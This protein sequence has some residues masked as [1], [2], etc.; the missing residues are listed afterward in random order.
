MAV[1]SPVKVP[2]LDYEKEMKRWNHV[3][4]ILSEGDP[5][6][7]HSP[8]Q[9]VWRKN[10]TTLWHYAA[11]EKKY[12]TPLFFVYSL[13]NKPYI[14]DIS[15]D[16]SVIKGLTKRGYDVY[17][18]DWG[19]PGPE[20]ADISFDTYILDY[21]E[22]GV[23]RAL[24]HSGAE[25]ISVVGYCLGGT[26]ASIFASITDLPIKNLVVA[27]VPID[28]SV[29][30][31]PD[32][33]LEGL[34]K[35]ELSVDRFVDVYGT[36][37][38]EW[39]NVMFRSL[40]PVN[41]SPYVG[42]LTRAHDSRYVDKWRRMDK[43]LNDVTPFAGAAFKQMFGDLMKDNKLAKGEL[44]IGGKH[45]DL[46]NID[47]SFLAISSANDSLIA[48]GQSL[49][50]MDLISSEDKTYKLVEAGHVSLALSGMFAPIVDEWLCERSG[51][52]GE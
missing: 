40:A 16:T 4:K 22:K 34:Q 44:V 50:V 33:W 48:E 43:W 46:S 2:V 18:L 24:R 14:L 7:E 35:G 38:P 29:G 32:K 28:Y 13:L 5:K 19:E 20:D 49:P 8:R 42:L 12:S 25:D 6:I 39:V 21:L 1:E 31:A 45:A 36:V 11:E 26:I 47:C 17:L 30:I 52:I 27:T 41:V 51:K 15:P 9:L 3:Y 10:K 37:P 23:K